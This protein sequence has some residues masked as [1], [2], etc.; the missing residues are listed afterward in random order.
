MIEKCLG[1]PDKINEVSDDAQI[2]IMELAWD[3]KNKASIEI[4]KAIK[5]AQD[6]CSSLLADMNMIN[7]DLVDL[8]NLATQIAN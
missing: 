7:A 8:K 5:S 3:E 6:C 1:F 2:E 4:T